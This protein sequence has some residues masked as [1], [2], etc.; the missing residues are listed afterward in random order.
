MNTDDILESAATPTHDALTNDDKTTNLKNEDAKEDAKKY[1]KEDAIV[2][3]RETVRRL[4]KDIQEVANDAALLQNGIYYE[5]DM[6]NFMQGHAMIL[7]PKDTP[8][9]N[10]LFFFHFRFPENYPFSP[11]TVKFH[12]HTRSQ[13]VRINPNLYE[14]GKVCL[15]LL[16]TWSGE[17]WSAC[18]TIRSVLLTLVTVL[19]EKPFLNEPGIHEGSRDFDKYH[20]L[21]RFFSLKDYLVQSYARWCSND[22]YEYETLFDGPIRAHYRKMRQD[23][24][25]ESLLRGLVEE[26]VDLDQASLSSSSV[27][28]TTV[29]IYG[30]R[31]TIQWKPVL[32][33]YV[34][35]C[36]A[37]ESP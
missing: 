13:R 26:T 19:N 15:S 37:H 28:V 3:S 36:E 27:G 16:N 23:G 11:P 12:N 10:G 2:V 22:V 25:L 8:Y 30:M 32:K 14:N 9:E 5:H 35:L 7:G 17:P 1:A 33:E 29:A 20:R 34:E 4:I 24:F 18:Q 31:A 6:D 21:V